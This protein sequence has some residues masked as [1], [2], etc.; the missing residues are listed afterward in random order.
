[1]ASLTDSTR[2][3]EA[4]RK[5]PF[6][7]RSA[8]W[9]LIAVA[10]AAVSYWAF[11]HAHVKRLQGVRRGV[12]YRL[13][14]PSELGMNYLVKYV[15]VKTVVSVQ[16]YD[17]RLHRGLISFGPPDGCR[18][19]EYVRRLGARPI[20][21]P[22]G[23]E[24][25]WPWL[26]PWQFEEFFKLVDDPANWPIAVHCQGGRHRTGTLAALFRLEYDRW[27]VDKVLAEMYGF[28]FGGAIRLQE[29]NLRT[30]LPRPHPDAAEWM[31]LIQYWSPL[32]GGEKFAD[33]EE[34]IRCLRSIR[35]CDSRI[36]DAVAAC[37]HDG[38]PFALPL[39]QRLI[40]DPQ[41]VLA[42]LA[43]EQAAV[44]LEELDAGRANWSMAAAL[45]ADF[46][47]PDEQQRLLH[48]LTD[49]AFQQASAERFDA[50]VDGV[51][52]RYTPNRIAYLRPL[53]DNETLH[54][55]QGVR[56]CRYCDTAVARLSA[57]ADENFP[58]AVPGWG[59]EA[60]NNGRVAARAWLDA[61]PDDSR[62]SQL[63][64]PTGHTAVLPGDPPPKEDLS[65]A[66][67]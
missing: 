39:A 51:T 45:I 25:S 21:W 38:K 62:L 27:P 26:T 24:K 13:G 49:S 44:T 16:L 57:I 33:Y 53:L 55:R 31:S 6:R 3:H 41:D 54:L 60:W 1:M 11:L 35:Q 29:H 12:F 40:D 65:R 66:K 7:R 63:K 20:E 37:L 56:Q 61:H 34:L 59:I 47:T 19:S 14:Q 58:D 22:M 5:Q 2:L 18:E 17:F 10:L 23:L 36:D 8:V 48:H 30:Y 64:P 9:A 28:K 4:P 46:G 43:T 67:M 42:R 52:N 15:G 50:V 32:V